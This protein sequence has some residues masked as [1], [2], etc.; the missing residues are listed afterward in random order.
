MEETLSCDL[1][2][3]TFDT[4]LERNDHL[5][6]HFKQLHCEL[7]GKSVLKI[8]DLLLEL[9]G[10]KQCHR[11]NTGSQ[12]QID[13]TKN[14]Q[15]ENVR[16]KRENV[17]T[18]RNKRARRQSKNT[19]AKL[20]VLAE[21]LKTETSENSLDSR[22]KSGRVRKRITYASDSDGD[23]VS[24]ASI[25]RDSKQSILDSVEVTLHIKNESPPPDEAGAS[26]DDA[27]Y[28]PD[29]KQEDAMSDS[30]HS[31]GENH[32]ELKTD[33]PDGAVSGDEILDGQT[34]DEDEYK[35]PQE[36]GSNAGRKRNKP[37]PMSIPCSLCGALFR[38]QRSL[39]IH[40]K[41]AH[42]ISPSTL[43][44]ICNKV[45]TSVGNLKQHKQT[46]NETRR[47][48]CSYCGKGFNLHFNLKDHINE[49]TGAKPY[50]CGVCGKAFGKASHRVA[51]MRVSVLS[52]SRIFSLEFYVTGVSPDSPV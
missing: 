8:G 48:I 44:D 46:H 3:F 13:G 45:F 5:L 24:I 30:E 34:A 26:S 4:R 18:T 20:I 36:E 41:Q 1:C 25:V 39:Q 7:C 16:S 28:A 50:V 2:K 22:R 14:C 43:C 32:L 21:P 31:Y 11:N 35:P 52:F 17:S 42:G 33:H 6:T 47:Y 27:D 38:T 29:I 12:H 10:P 19:E 23:N 9:H 51:H 37:Q 49:H 40:E 15:D